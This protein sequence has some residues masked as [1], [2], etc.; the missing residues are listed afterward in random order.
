M[1]EETY[2]LYTI[3]GCEKNASQ[4]EIK[5]AYRKKAFKL[6]P[7]RNRN[8]PNA[9]E[10]FQQ[11]QAAYDILKDPDSRRRYDQVGD[12]P[13]QQR[14][15]SQRYDIQINP[16]DLPYQLRELGRSRIPTP[17]KKFA[18]TV[19]FLHIPASTAFFGGKL[20]K[21]LKLF[22]ICPD[23]KGIGSNDGIEYKRCPECNGEGALIPGVLGFLAPCLECSTIGYLIP[24][25]KRCKRCHGR[26]VITEKVSFPVDV[27][28]GIP[29]EIPLIFPLKGDEFP[30]KETADLILF[31]N[32]ILPNG[33]KRDGDDL[34]YI[35][36]ISDEEIL[37]GTAFSF[38]HPNNEI[39]Y[40]YTPKGEK[41]NTKRVK[42]MQ[43]MGMPARG[44]LQFTGHLFIIFK[45][46]HP[47]CFTE[48]LMLTSVFF[49]RLRAKKQLLVDAPD[50]L[51]RAVWERLEVMRREEAYRRKHGGK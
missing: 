47:N 35:K 49:T 33:M 27:E 4:E 12:A 39:F 10:K 44:N 46:V 13:Q 7:D 6:H 18:P 15:Q 48:S 34:Y 37:N 36:E 23:C 11:L 17:G 31:P 22:R 9:N 38:T 3:I 26:R 16:V 5:R 51:N 2:S 28:I 40:C 45:H 20:V 19:R 43:N 32:V 41:I 25:S 21:D 14:Q 42:W 50:D 1:T 24:S 8:D 30:G 29:N